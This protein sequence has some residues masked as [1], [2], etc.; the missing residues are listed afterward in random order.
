MY[1]RQ[2]RLESLIETVFNVSIGFVVSACAWPIVAHLFGYPYSLSHNLGIT[3]IF[4][5]LSITRGFIVRRCF[6]G[7]LQRAAEILSRKIEK[8]G[9]NA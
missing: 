4:T 6:E 5:V 9:S 8:E 2:T 7:R 3:T 1:H